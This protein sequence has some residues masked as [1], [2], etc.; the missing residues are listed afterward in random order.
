M[1]TGDILLVSGQSKQAKLIQQFQQ[2]A[3][4]ASGKYNHSGL[5]YVAPSGV[6]VAE[7]S[8]ITGRKVRAAAVLTPL[9]SYSKGKYDLLILTPNFNLDPIE[10]ER[11]LFQYLG[12][13]YD[14]WSLI[15]DQVIRTLFEKWVGRE[16]KKA[17][18]QMV[19]HEFSQFISNE[20]ERGVFPEWYK[21]DVSKMY[22]SKNYTHEKC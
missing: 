10:F 20:C 4:K 19:C 15:H 22:H 3:D 11:V 5:I 1:K 12:T 6:Y 14:Y 8:Y 2:K 17:A 9:D 18:R 21:G 7:E 13:P 16:G